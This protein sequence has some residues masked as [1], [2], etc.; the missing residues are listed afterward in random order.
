MF[1]KKTKKAKMKNVILINGKARVG[2]DYIA[3]L[4]TKD[5][6]AKGKKVLRLAY[7]DKLKDMICTMFNISKGELDILK[8][9]ENPYTLNGVTMRQIL[10]RFGTE[11]INQIDTN[12]WVK[13]VKNIIDETN[14][15][16]YIISDFRYHK[17]FN[18]I[19]DCYNIKT[20]QILGNESI[21]ANDHVSENSLDCFKFD[22]VVDNTDHEKLDLSEVLNSLEC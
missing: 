1:F 11:I 20:I 15:D 18:Y 12:F 10:Q 9:A 7:A 4:I 19:K 17:E 21:K 2:K 14:Y 3:D 22:F 16:F 13:S 5:L 6:E 8:N